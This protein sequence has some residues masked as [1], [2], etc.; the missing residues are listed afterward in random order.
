MIVIAIVAVAGGGLFWRLSRLIT[1]KQKETDAARLGSLLLSSRMM[2]INTKSDWEL[3]MRETKEGWTLRLIAL[4]DPGKEIKC[5]RLSPL[6]IR[7]EMYE[8][9][10]AKEAAKTI[11]KNLENRIAIRFYSTGQVAPFG[12]LEL[13][14]EKIQIPGYFRQTEGSDLGPMHPE[15]LP[16]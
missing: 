14:R 15:D 10:P 16:T 1:A 8:E 2:A 3:E 13:P 12:T 7:F 9:K 4:E 6:T 11:Q 5:G